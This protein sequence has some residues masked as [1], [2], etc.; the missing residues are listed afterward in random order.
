MIWKASTSGIRVQIAVLNGGGVRM[1]MPEGNL[2]V[3]RINELLPFQNRL[4][5]LEL[6]G[7]EIR[8]AIETGLAD[9]DGSGGGFAYTAG[10]RYEADSS[11][12]A[13]KRVVKA[14][15]RN[16]SGKWVPLNDSMTYRV[17]TNSYLAGGGN[18]YEVFRD[19]KGYRYDTGFSDAEAFMDYA[20]HAGKIK[21]MSE[22]CIVYK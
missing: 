19:S 6:S 5:L 21:P 14:D 1:D 9:S 18:G 11:K 10:L 20:R 13:W 4:I 3:A 2:T 15:V 22:T 17:I 7:K 16:D 8:T 12:P